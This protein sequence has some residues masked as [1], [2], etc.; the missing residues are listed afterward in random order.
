MKENL[1]RDRNVTEVLS[2][3]LFFFDTTEKPDAFSRTR[4]V[5]RSTTLRQNPGCG[6]SKCRTLKGRKRRRMTSLREY[7]LIVHARK[8]RIKGL[9]Q[10]S[11]L[12]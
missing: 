12:M 6:E 11:N 1:F 5:I 10:L 3:A 8:V 7:G 2:E 9:S 4:H